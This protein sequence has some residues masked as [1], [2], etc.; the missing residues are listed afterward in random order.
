MPTNPEHLRQQPDPGTDL[1]EFSEAMAA[2]LP[3]WDTH[4]RELI[5]AAHHAD[6][7]ELVWDS[8]PRDSAFAQHRFPEAAVLTGPGGARLTAFRT[9]SRDQVVIS[10]LRPDWM[11][12]DLV[13]PGDLRIPKALAVSR[14][15]VQAAAQVQERLL[16]G[17]EQAVWRVRVRALAKAAAGIAQASEQWNALAESFRAADGRFDTAG[18]KEGKAVRN[19]VAWQ[20]VETF[21]AHGHEVLAGVK[22]AVTGADYIRS[23]ISA[24]L[25][26]A[27]IVA[28]TLARATTMRSGWEDVTSGLATAPPGTREIYL[29]RAHRLRDADGWRYAEELSHSGAALARAAAHLTDRIGTR[30]PTDTDRVQA[31]LNRSSANAQGATAAPAPAPA[32]QLP[33]AERRTR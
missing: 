9:R 18:Y 13:E 33:V 20:H 26:E 15:P 17:Y 28:S 25:R 31:A 23:P 16:P 12:A 21:L 10:A 11:P 7:A 5:S 30:T 8:A 24:D 29:E 4:I 22:A 19:A 3:G 32:P 6:L 27:R 2:R 1:R 14:H